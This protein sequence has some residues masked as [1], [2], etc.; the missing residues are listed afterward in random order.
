MIVGVP[1]E[2]KNNENRVGVTPAGVREL[3]RAGH[4]VLVAAGAGIGSGFSDDAYRAKDAEIVGGAEEVWGRADIVVK[5][6]EPLEQE[7]S[8]MRE[9]QILITYLHLA[10][11]KDLTLALM[12]SGVIGIGYETVE[13]NGNLPLL[14][15]M[16]EVAGRMAP[17]VG[18]DSLAYPNGG[19]GRLISGVPGVA[20]ANVMILGGGIV[21][22]NAAKVAAGMGG[23]VT[24]LDVSPGRLKYLDDVLPANC[25]VVHSDADSIDNYLQTADL[26]IGCVLVCGRRAPKLITRSMLHRMKPRGVIVDVAVDQGGCVETTRPTTHENPTY[27]EE[28]VL[29]YCVA[30]MPG[31]FPQTSTVALTNVTLPYVLQVANKGVREAVSQNRSLAEGVNVWGGN[32]TCEPV[33]ESL[34]LTF[35][36]LEKVL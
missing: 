13:E 16:S 17:L 19:L 2:I 34:D 23:R 30:N 1:Q 5:V 36:S 15:P 21:G 27:Y 6:K 20:P 12:E 32:L 24:V 8:L 35:R 26:V 7:Y 14:A 22:L 25:T 33:A 11:D 10:A 29:H 9:G 3:S 28:G 4:T 31:A 18:A